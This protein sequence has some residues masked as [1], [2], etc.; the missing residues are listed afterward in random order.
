MTCQPI[1]EIGAD[2]TLCRP[3]TLSVRS[4]GQRIASLP[5]KIGA[6]Q[7]IDGIRLIC[8]NPPVLD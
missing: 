5:M 6:R 7:R 3:T 4:S 2:A 8:D 1:H